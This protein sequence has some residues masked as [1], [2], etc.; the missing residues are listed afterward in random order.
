M[1][2]VQGLVVS[3]TL[4]AAVGIGLMLVGVAQAQLD[5]FTGKFTLTN[6]VKWGKTVLQPGDYT[7]T[8]GSS[9][10]PIDAVVSDS[11]GR[12]VARFTTSVIDTGKSSTGNALLLRE[13]GGQLHVYALT[14]ANLGKVLLYN[15]ALAREPVLEA[16]APQTVPVVFSKR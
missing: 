9:S 7:I 11:S 8:I 14:L 12:A 1:K 2:K 10:M 4:F 6:Q 5:A 13:K 16:R 15:Q 3:K